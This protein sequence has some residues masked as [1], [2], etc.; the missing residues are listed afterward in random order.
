MEDRSKRK[1]TIIT[2][3]YL[4]LPILY[5]AMTSSLMFRTTDAW[6]RFQKPYLVMLACCCTSILLCIVF[7]IL[8]AKRVPSSVPQTELRHRILWLGAL[9]IVGVFGMFYCLYYLSES[10]NLLSF[11]LET[12]L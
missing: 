12:I 1:I 11:L 3:I 10:E 5:A 4:C 6:D 7:L 2:G 9:Q 8:D